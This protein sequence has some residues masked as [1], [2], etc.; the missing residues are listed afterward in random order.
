MRTIVFCLLVILSNELRSQTNTV[1]HAKVG[2]VAPNATY[3][4]VDHVFPFNR[5][6][7]VIVKGN[8]YFLIDK[9]F[10]PV[11]PFNKYELI[12]PLIG[13]D[14]FRGS[15]KFKNDEFFNHQGTLIYTAPGNKLSRWEHRPDGYIWFGEEKGNVSIIPGQITCVNAKGKKIVIKTT[16]AEEFHEWHEGLVRVK[17]LDKYGYMDTTGKMVIPAQYVHAKEFSEGLAAVAKLNEFGEAKW[18]FIDKTGKVQIPFQYSIMPSSFGFGYA[19]ILPKVQTDTKFSL[20]NHN[21]EIKVNVPVSSKAEANTDKKFIGGF[22]RASLL[23]G[24]DIFGEEYSYQTR[25]A[26]A[27][28]PA[29]N[30]TYPNWFVEEPYQDGQ[31]VF[32]RSTREGELK[33]GILD[34]ENGKY[35]DPIFTEITLF[36]PVSNLA[37]A[38]LETGKDNN[39]FPIYREGYINRQG[40][41]VLVKQTKSNW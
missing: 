3:L 11:I 32:V 15:A 14:V 6:A 17:M 24:C 30:M 27:G 25:F 22:M 23:G 39:G 13:M 29:R 38:K 4:D 35:I 16:G 18:G 26:Q 10:K 20:I 12:T 19:V 37:Y 33:K 2:S 5:G 31:I 9:N 7:A 40:V 41:F 8:A 34:I 36:D 21:G 1:D 28:L